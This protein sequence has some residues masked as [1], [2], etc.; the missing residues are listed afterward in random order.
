MAANNNAA[1]P[2]YASDFIKGDVDN[3]VF[4]GN[5]H[6]DNLYS[7]VIAL[8]AELWAR[9]QRSLIVES[10]LETKG[11]VTKEMIENYVPT[12]DEKKAWGEERNAMV[13]RLYAVFARD[14]SQAAPFGSEHRP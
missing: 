1:R 3:A 14:T 11:K 6:I 9:N 7:V 4:T 5:A 2:T 13:K 8:G 12:E 10:L